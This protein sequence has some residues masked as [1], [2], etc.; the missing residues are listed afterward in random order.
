VDVGGHSLFKHVVV[1]VVRQDR[2]DEVEEGLNKEV[3]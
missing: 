3:D 1:V 2:V